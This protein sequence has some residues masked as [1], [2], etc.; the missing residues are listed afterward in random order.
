MS[1]WAD[2]PQ[3]AQ[4]DALLE[5]VGRLRVDEAEAIF[6][7]FDDGEDRAV[8]AR[9]F[10]ASDRHS[11]QESDVL[12]EVMLEASRVMHWRAV[13]VQ[14]NQDRWESVRPGVTE[15]VEECATALAARHR[16]DD[17]TRWNVAAYV[18]ATFPW[19]S[20]I[21]PMHPDDRVFI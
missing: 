3:A 19:R 16:I 7:L 12:R 1:A 15:A 17:R 21:G 11:K 8:Y 14:S 13:G 10:T 18:A 5:R 2:S 9:A 6:N 20:V 4:I